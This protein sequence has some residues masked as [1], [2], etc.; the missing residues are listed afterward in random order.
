MFLKYLGREA[1]RVRVSQIQEKITVEPQ[2][3]FEVDDA[4]GVALVAGY[5]ETFIPVEAPEQKEK[6]KPKRTTKRKT[7]ELKGKELT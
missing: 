6:S 7:Q 3:T 4:L 1:T 2:E 5:R